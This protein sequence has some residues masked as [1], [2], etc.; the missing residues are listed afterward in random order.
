MY[1]EKL[2]PYQRKKL[3]EESGVL[4]GSLIDEELI[5]RKPL[6]TLDKNITFLDPSLTDLELM[7]I[8][9]NIYDIYGCRMIPFKDKIER[10]ILLQFEKEQTKYESEPQ[11]EYTNDKIKNI[12][13]FRKRNKPMVSMG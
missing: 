13:F 9:N 2:K 8:W 7:V 6:D 10:E 12:D 11:Q 3:L 4:I 5:N 1:D